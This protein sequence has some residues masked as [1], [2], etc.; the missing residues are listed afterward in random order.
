MMRYDF[1]AISQAEV[2]PEGWIRDRP[3]LARTGIQEY[4]RNDGSVRREYRPPEEVFHADALASL[5]GVPVT[6]DHPGT[7]TSKNP[8]A[9]IGSSLTVGERDDAN[10]RGE[11]VIHNP[12]AMGPKRELSLGYSVRLDETPGEIDGQRYDAVQRDIRVNHIAVVHRG[13]AGNAR[14]RLDHDDAATEPV[15]K[16][17]SMSENKLV[18]VRLDG[19]EYQASPEVKRA[20]ERHDEALAAGREQT[21]AAN[22]RADKAEGERDDLKQKLDESK[23][24]IAKI[25]AD[26]AVQVRARLALESE[27]AKHGVQV[28]EDATDRQIQEA[29]IHKLRGDVKLDGKSDDYVQS[30]FDAA[31]EDAGSQ[32]ANT[33]SQRIAASRSDTEDPYAAMTARMRDA[34]KGAA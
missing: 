28:K 33:A 15:E 9:I 17:T 10:V 25:R 30:R 19:L 5:R 26:A 23:A 32:A 34:W 27:A 29:V 4:R 21:A 20:L 8:L 2:T 13:R 7:V 22:T 14:L 12:E 18:S 31:V 24:E 11:I 16:D 3:I 6:N 1:V